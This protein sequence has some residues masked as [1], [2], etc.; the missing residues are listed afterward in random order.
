MLAVWPERG[1][2]DVT[3]GDRRARSG[4]GTRVSV[5]GIA[6]HA[7][8]R[9]GAPVVVAVLAAVTRLA[10]AGLRE[11]ADALREYRTQCRG[12]VGK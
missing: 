3:A 8:R 2:V 12:A 9:Q 7:H 11:H 6:E 1:R 10:H 5:S 4:D